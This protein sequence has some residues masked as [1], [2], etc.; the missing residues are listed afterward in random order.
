MDN[1]IDLNMFRQIMLS[2]EFEDI[3][4]DLNKFDKHDCHFYYDESNNIRKLWLDEDDFNAPVDCDFVL[5]GV[6]HI[7]QPQNAN[8]NE[9]KNQLRLPI[10]AKELKFKYIRKSKD[11]L[12]CLSEPKVKLFLQWLYQSDLYVH[13]SNVNNLYY[14]VVDIVDSLDESAFAPFIFQIKNE[15]YKI[16]VTNYTDFYQL[17]VRYNYPN[18][19]SNNITSF[20]QQIID[21]IDDIGELSFEMELLRQCLKQGRK[22]NELI[23]LKDNPEKTIIDNYFLF[24]LRPVGVFFNAHHT[25]DNEYCIESQ[26]EKF[27]L[28]YGNSKADNYSFI[29]SKDNPLIQVSDCIVGLLGKYYTFINRISLEEA[30]EIFNVITP[31]QKSTLKMFAQ[32]IKKSEDLSKLLLNAS[33]SIDEHEIGAFVLHTALAVD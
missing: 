31:T 14:A 30:Y 18:V 26:F 32:I 24:Y 28:Y 8:I 33:E 7:N 13:Y 15:L 23:F 12:G 6:M 17:L 25:F 2:D 29:D 9:L 16:A 11:F 20:Y 21:F 1:R 10:S 19:T 3:S 5:G 4:R 27:E 22:Q